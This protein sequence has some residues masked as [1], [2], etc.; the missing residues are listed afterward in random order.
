MA[1]KEIETGTEGKTVKEALSEEQL[2]QFRDKIQ[3]W[4]KAITDQMEGHQKQLSALDAKYKTYQEVLD[5]LV[6]IVTAN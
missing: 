1:V 6:K 3:E 5:E 2:T 4:Q